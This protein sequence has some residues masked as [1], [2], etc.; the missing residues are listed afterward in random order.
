MAVADNQTFFPVSTVR[1]YQEKSTDETE[2]DE[3]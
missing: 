2:D 3:S 1:S